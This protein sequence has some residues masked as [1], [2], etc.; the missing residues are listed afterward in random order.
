MRDY[1]K[2]KLDMSEFNRYTSKQLDGIFELNDNLEIIN[3]VVEECGLKYATIHNFF[4]RPDEV[5]DFLKHIPSEDKTESMMK[6]K[7]TYMASNAPGFQQPLES[8]LAK[9]LC[10]NLYELGKRTG[11][12]KY[13]KSQV[14]FNYY[15]NCCYPGMKACQNN[16]LPHIDPFSLACNMYLTE[17]ENTGTSFLKFISTEGREYYNAT[18]LARSKR[19]TEEYIKKYEWSQEQ[20]K[21]FSKN[22]IEGTDISD[23]V[24]YEGDPPDEPLPR[25]EK[26]H[27]IKADRNMCSM[28]RGNRWHGIT[29]DADKE[30]NIRYSLVGVIK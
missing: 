29:Y 25:F 2:D 3:D 28:Y 21:Y 30:T 11:L 14:R 17:V 4:K 16:W 23:W 12:H 6:D 24:S 26:Y 1:N 8:K 9:S 13:E 10:D 15:T 5:I 19:A 20:N 7:F 27:Y 22:P 18:Q